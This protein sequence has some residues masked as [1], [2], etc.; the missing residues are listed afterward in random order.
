MHLIL[1]CTFDPM[2]LTLT[3]DGIGNKI[4]AVS[5]GAVKASLQRQTGNPFLLCRFIIKMLK[6][7]NKASLLYWKQTH[8]FGLS[9][10]LFTS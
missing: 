6:A 4:L 10:I 3:H 1:K 7:N 9:K 8:T 2:S 5:L